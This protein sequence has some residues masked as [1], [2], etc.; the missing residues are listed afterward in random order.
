MEHVMCGE[1]WAGEQIEGEGKHVVEYCGKLKRSREVHKS[2]IKFAS[3]I[4]CTEEN[5][6]VEMEAK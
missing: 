3:L 2:A 4:L 6:R 1:K 5:M